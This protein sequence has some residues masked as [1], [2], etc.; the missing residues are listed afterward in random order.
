MTLNKIFNPKIENALIMTL[1]ALSFFNYAIVNKLVIDNNSYKF[2]FYNNTILEEIWFIAFQSAAIE[3]FW[4]INIILT[5]RN[6]KL[7]IR[8]VLVA[9]QTIMIYSIS[10]NLSMMLNFIMNF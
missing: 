1:P 9:L 2:P 4:V 10:S 3:L 8:N 5:I 6:I 7:G